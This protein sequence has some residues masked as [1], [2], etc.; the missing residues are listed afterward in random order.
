MQALQSA[1][2]ASP[3]DPPPPATWD[4]RIYASSSVLKSIPSMG[5]L[6]FVGSARVPVINFAGSGAGDFKK[7]ENFSRHT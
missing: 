5:A 1:V 2:D 7:V 4:M 3:P 6:S